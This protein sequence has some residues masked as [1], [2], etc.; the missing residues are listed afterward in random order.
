M[1]TRRSQRELPADRSR[2]Q[3]LVFL[4]KMD[5][6]GVQHPLHQLSWEGLPHQVLVMAKAADRATT[7]APAV[8]AQEE[9]GATT[10]LEAAPKVDDVAQEVQ[11]MLLEANRRRAMAVAR[12]AAAL[13]EVRTLLLL[14]LAPWQPDIIGPPRT[15]G[16]AFGRGMATSER[17]S[18]LMVRRTF[19]PYVTGAMAHVQGRLGKLGQGLPSS[20]EPKGGQEAVCSLG[21]K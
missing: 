12:P 14:M 11:Q 19:G 2:V 9:A 4:A 7:A 20:P 18:M 21:W 6:A 1:V 5:R 13:A 15:V 10:E 8:A 3:S 17:V 16:L